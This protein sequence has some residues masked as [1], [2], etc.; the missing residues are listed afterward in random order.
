V[1]RMQQQ[2]CDHYGNRLLAFHREHRI[3][4]NRVVTPSTTTPVRFATLRAVPP[5]ARPPRTLLMLRL[6][7]CILLGQIVGF[8]FVMFVIEPLVREML[9][10][11]R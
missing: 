1:H 9:Q 8:A 2:R 5:A 10:V 11:P 6:I 3:I 7:A 4:D